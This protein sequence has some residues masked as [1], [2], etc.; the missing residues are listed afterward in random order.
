MLSL[1]NSGVPQPTNPAEE[2]TTAAVCPFTPPP[3]LCSQQDGHSLWDAFTRGPFRRL[4]P[5]VLS[6]LDWSD[7]VALDNASPPYALAP[8]RRPRITRIPHAACVAGGADPR[9]LS[10]RALE[11]KF[12]A[13]CGASPEI[14]AEEADGEDEESHA[15]WRSRMRHLVEDADYKGGC[16]DSGSRIAVAAVAS[17]LSL[18]PDPVSAALHLPLSVHDNVW[19]VY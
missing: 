6:F 1:G 19:Y 10:E 12:A 4:L 15:Y 2:R 17:G 14:A 7:V 5:L 16:N 8:T 13:I 18:R 3:P 11:A 9:L